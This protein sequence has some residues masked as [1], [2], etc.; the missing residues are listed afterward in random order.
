MS[1]KA[2]I[3]RATTDAQ[4]QMYSLDKSSQADLVK[5]YRNAAD[6]IQRKIASFA[7]ADGNLS[8]YQLQDLLTQINARLDQLSRSRD[9]MLVDDLRAAAELGTM[10]FGLQHSPSGEAVGGGVISAV[11]LAKINDDAVSFVRTFISDADGLQL[12]DRIWRIDRQAREKVG[13]AIENAVIQ[14]QG[15]VEAA[16]AFISNG[17]PVPIDVQ[18]KIDMANADSVAKAASGALFTGD[19]N[20]MFNAMR[21]FRTEINRAHGIAYAKGFM[22]QPDAAGLK[23]TLSPA[24]PKHDICDLLSTQNLYGLGP[25]VYPTVEKTGWPAHPNTLSFLVGVYKDEVTSEDKA[26]KETP[27]QALQR[28]TPL[29]RVG[30]LGVNK[31]QVFDE[32]KLTQGMIRAPWK[33]VAK[34]IGQ[35]PNVTPK[36][37]LPAVTKSDLLSLDEMLA[38]GKKMADELINTSLDDNKEVKSDV[39]Y[40][41]IKTRLNREVGTSSPAKIK[42]GGKGAESVMAASKMY[43]DTWTKAAD[44]FGDLYAKFSQ[45]RGFAVTILN[46][47]AGRM[48]KIIGQTIYAKG[49]EGFIQTGSF[50]TSVHEYAHRLQSVMP[51]LDGYFQELHHRRTA[52]DPLRRLKDIYPTHGY[53]RSEVTREDN[54]VHAYQGRIYNFSNSYLG[55]YGALEVMTI[56][57]EFVLGGNMNRLKDLLKGDREMFDLVI[58]LLFNYVPKT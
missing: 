20:P 29:Q 7:G 22:Q 28:L 43:P 9:I 48:H 58:G 54:Y 19:G 33:S 36:K 39:L 4:R 37:P 18:S 27:T 8:L 12:S 26:G 50:S 34:R 51:E 41:A 40:E 13:N 15:A 2:K 21:V 52:D 25:G 10:P 32:G 46:S 49:G 23:F 55:K 38:R 24:H 31:N 16:R 44:N 14:G 30:V 6:E 35:K 11:D 45:S 53:G 3:K 17:K 56:G 57:F 47:Q 5:L 42:N 1:T